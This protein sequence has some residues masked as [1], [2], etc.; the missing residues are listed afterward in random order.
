MYVFRLLIHEREHKGLSKLYC[1]INTCV[2]SK[3]EFT[4]EESLQSHVKMHLD[5]KRKCYII[6]LLDW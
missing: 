5:A 3:K 6:I 2:Y 4:N 1:P